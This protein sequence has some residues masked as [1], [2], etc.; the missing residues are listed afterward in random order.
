MVGLRPPLGTI[1]RF[2]ASLK[3]REWDTSKSR[4]ADDPDSNT[5]VA[6]IVVARPRGHH[7]WGLLREPAGRRG[8]EHARCRL[9]PL[10]P[11]GTARMVNG[12][13]VV[14]YRK[15]GITAEIGTN[16]DDFRTNQR[17]MRVEERFA[18]AVVRPW[19]SAGSC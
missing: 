17:T 6:R 2:A 13:G 3:R 8:D 7:G 19:C 4:T 12:T 11:P 10:R 18:T 9:C 15:G 1:G 14:I 5:A 16:A